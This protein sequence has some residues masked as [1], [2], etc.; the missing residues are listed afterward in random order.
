MKLNKDDEYETPREVWEAIKQSIPR[1]VTLW[2]PFYCN[3][4]SGRDLKRMGFK[5]IHKRGDFFSSNHGDVV[6]SNPPFSKKK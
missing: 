5:A 1:D 6:V 3:G 4:K 2:E